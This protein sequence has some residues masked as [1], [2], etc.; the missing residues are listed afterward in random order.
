[1]SRTFRVASDLPSGKGKN[2]LVLSGIEL[3][4]PLEMD[5]DEDPLQDDEV[6]LSRI[7]GHFTRELKASDP[8]VT[9]EEGGERLFYRFR[10]VPP[11][12]YSI[13]ARVGEDRWASILEGILVTTK[14]ATWNEQDLSDEPEAFTPRGADPPEH[15][16]TIAEPATES[17]FY[18]YAGD[19]SE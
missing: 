7:D 14:K 10:D 8:D 19:G 3:I 4:V 11:G 12:V 16:A 17:R 2:T 5:L 9:R 13:Q 18:E 15:E 1:V 6:R